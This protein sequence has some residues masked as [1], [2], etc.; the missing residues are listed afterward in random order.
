MMKNPYKF[1]REKCGLTQ[2]KFCDEYGF[3]KQ[4][5]IS[6]EQ[7]VYEDLS[8]RMQTSIEMACA[9]AGIDLKDELW[10]QFAKLRTDINM[11]DVAEIK[12]DVIVIDDEEPV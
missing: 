7:G 9:A 8:N 11:N 5:L 4:T 10:Q 6:I 3:A 12:T 2:K 1:L